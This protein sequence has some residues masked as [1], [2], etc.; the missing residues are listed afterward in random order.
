M[1]FRE[2][3]IRGERSI[4]DNFVH[5]LSDFAINGWEYRTE[6]LNNWQYYFFRD[7]ARD[8][9]VSLLFRE[10]EQCY[11]IPNIVPL[12][13]SQITIEEYNSYLE[14]FRNE[15]VIPCSQQE[16]FQTQI[17]IEIE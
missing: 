2:L 6:I 3:Y 7:V 17:R 10:Q 15:I 1:P 13:R 8:F 12:K 16:R 11:Y 9:E 14:M 5:S 4:L